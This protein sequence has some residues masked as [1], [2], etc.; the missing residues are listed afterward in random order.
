MNVQHYRHMSNAELQAYSAEIAKHVQDA[1]RAGDMREAKRHRK[2]LA[3]I[4]RVQ[5]IRRGHLLE[6]W[7]SM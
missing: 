7:R 6:W 5:D 1:V 2:E 3:R 4:R